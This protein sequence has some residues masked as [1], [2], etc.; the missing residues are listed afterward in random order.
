MRE[1]RDLATYA[2]D[3]VA[4]M[5]KAHLTRGICDPNNDRGMG[6]G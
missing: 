3:S 5:R 6:G 1:N 2:Q 4:C